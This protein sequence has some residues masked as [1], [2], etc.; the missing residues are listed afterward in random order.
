MQHV[1]LHQLLQQYAFFY[2]KSFFLHTIILL[3]VI[4]T[5]AAA[6]S[7]THAEGS[8]VTVGKNTKR[9]EASH[10]ESQRRF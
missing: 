2:L 1:V 4:T 9:V 5:K 10:S 3:K 6:A 8:A 7:E